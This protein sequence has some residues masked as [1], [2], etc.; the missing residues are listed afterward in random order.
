M[1]KTAAPANSDPAQLLAKRLN[2]AQHRR[3]DAY[4]K[5][6]KSGKLTGKDLAAT[7]AARSI[8]YSEL[9]QTDEAMA[10]MLQAAKLDPADPEHPL[11][12]AIIYQKRGQYPAALDQ[13]RRALTLGMEPDRVYAHRGQIYYQMGKYDEALQDFGKIALAEE[14]N[15]S[16]PYVRLWY[17]WTLARAGRPLPQALKQQLDQD[18][19]GA[20]PRAAYGMFTGTSSPETVLAQVDKL[21]GDERL[22]ALCEAYFYIGQFYLVHG[23]KPKARAYFEKTRATGLTIYS[24][25]EAAVKELEQ[26]DKEMQPA[27]AGL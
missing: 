25:H 16:Q 21:P 13:A 2:D 22:M 1:V 8:A 24:E 10:D 19:N 6:I 11:N 12:L 18:L 14:G 9:V 5:V 15:A 27:A 20:W 3:V 17:L 23:D 26:M 7:Y 4:D